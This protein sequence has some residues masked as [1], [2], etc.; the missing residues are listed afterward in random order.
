MKVVKREE[1]KRDEAAERVLRR[2]AGR[3]G[4]RAAVTVTATATATTLATSRVGVAVR[5]A[6]LGREARRG[7]DPLERTVGHDGFP[8]ALLSLSKRV[9][10][11]GDERSVRA[12]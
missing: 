2:L 10:P 12:G 1:E 4:V 8:F 5:A 7:A 9:M 6:A 11:S 3:S